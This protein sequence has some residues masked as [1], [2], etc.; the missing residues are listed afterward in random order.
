MLCDATESEEVLY[1]ALPEVSGIV[2]S[3]VVPSLKVT[4]PV[5][6]PTPGA[7]AVTLAVKVTDCPKLDG[8]GEDVTL[9]RVSALL[10]VRL[11]VPLEAE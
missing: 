1:I 9:L 7:T 10:T 3:V 8:F 2:A 4:E 5:G 11:S 6:V